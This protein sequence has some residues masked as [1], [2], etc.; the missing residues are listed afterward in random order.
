[1]TSRVHDLAIGIYAALRSPAGSPCWKK[2]YKISLWAVDIARSL[3]KTSV[4]PVLNGVSTLIV[5]ASP[6]AR[7][8]TRAFPVDIA[9]AVIMIAAVGCGTSLL[10]CVL[11]EFFPSILFQLPFPFVLA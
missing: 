6:I 2:T 10:A 3:S 1:M 9:D 5:L 8:G 4:S 7:F 11:V